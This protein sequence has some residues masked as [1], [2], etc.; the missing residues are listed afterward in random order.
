LSRF[1]SNDPG[2]LRTVDQ[3][4][5]E[6]VRTI[7]DNVVASLTAHPRRKFIQVEVSFFARWWADQ[8]SSVRDA[9]RALV[10]NGQLE[11]VNGGWTMHDEAVNTY[12]AMV[13]QLTYGSN[14]LLSELNVTV[15]IAWHIGVCSNNPRRLSA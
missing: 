6:Y 1:R 14:F 7:L 2:W 8:P 9:V 4:H 11:F 10:S 13:N 15:D 12:E 5:T 3:Y